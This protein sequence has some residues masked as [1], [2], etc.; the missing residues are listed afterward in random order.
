MRLLIRDTVTV[1]GHGRRRVVI[2]ILTPGTTNKTQTIVQ[3]HIS[4]GYF[5]L[6]AVETA[7]SN[8]EI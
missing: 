5:Q 2:R 4:S 6:L 1:T 8:P 7:N 3:R